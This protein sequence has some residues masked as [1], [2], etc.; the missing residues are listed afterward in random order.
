MVEIVEQYHERGIVVV[1]SRLRETAARI[2]YQSGIV[3]LVG[4]DH[5][6]EKLVD[7]VD[8][9]ERGNKSPDSVS[10]QS[11]VQITFDDDFAKASTTVRP[12]SAL[13]KQ[14]VSTY[15]LRSD[16]PS[17]PRIPPL[18]PTITDIQEQTASLDSVDD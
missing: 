15:T 5:M 16:A 1:F 2:F 14:N 4:K 7:A 13:S 11:S 9:L 6:F 12:E 18:S 8:A 17:D 3:D 10:G